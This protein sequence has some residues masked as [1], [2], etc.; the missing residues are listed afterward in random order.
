MNFY[1]T[2][3]L[4]WTIILILY[5]FGWSSFNVSLE[6][7]ILLFFIFSISFSLIMGFFRSSEFKFIKP[8]QT[9]VSRKI[10]LFIILGFILD[11][12]YAKDIPFIFIIIGK[13]SYMDFS[14][15]P[16]VHV[17]LC[18]SGMLE[19]LYLFNNILYSKK[20]QRKSLIIMYLMIVTMFLLLFSRAMLSIIIAGCLILFFCFYKSEKGIYLSLKKIPIILIILLSLLYSFGYLGN[21]RSGAKG[22]DST[23]V[24]SFGRF[25]D[26]YPSFL[27]DEYMWPYLYIT[28]PL[29]NLNNAVK[30]NAKSTDPFFYTIIP[31]VISNRIRG[32]SN[33]FWSTDERYN[34]VAEYL[35]ASTGFIDPFVSGN[36]LGMYI[37]Y[38]VLILYCEVCTYFCKFTKYKNLSISVSSIL[39]IFNFFYGTISF[40]AISLQLIILVMVS[41][42]KKIKIKI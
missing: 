18:A 12:I 19:A 10:P 9:E 42:L 13:S 39:L 14:G 38:F 41:L 4:L 22:T 25:N 2:Y 20:S 40:S 31:D 33:D 3:S 15:I 26:S 7:S 16:I 24:R 11:F 8:N 5:S 6:P 28:N 23:K 1:Y 32:Y 27:P 36:I 29:A 35:N 30:T 34:L 17:F 37:Y 21:V